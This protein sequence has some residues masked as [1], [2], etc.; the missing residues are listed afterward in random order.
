MKNF[1]KEEMRT[2]GS[3]TLDVENMTDDEIWEA[4]E[5]LEEHANE[6][7]FANRQANN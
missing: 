5:A 3:V 1:I 4:H 2:K 7:F 6:V